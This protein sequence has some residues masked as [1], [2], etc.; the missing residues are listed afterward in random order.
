MLAWKDVE[1]GAQTLGGEDNDVGTVRGYLNEHKSPGGRSAEQRR[2]G[3]KKFATP[4]AV[5][6]VVNPRCRGE[7]K[8]HIMLSPH[9]LSSPVSPKRR[10]PL[11]NRIMVI[12]Q[13]AL[14]IKSAHQ[15]GSVKKVLLQS[16]IP[17]VYRLSVRTFPDS[18]TSRIPSPSQPPRWPS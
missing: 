9:P 1:R 5:S 10:S 14:H 16:R 7:I 18:L 3:R 11:S 17:V 15:G 8:Y 13:N 6:V 4:Q 2:R 12:I